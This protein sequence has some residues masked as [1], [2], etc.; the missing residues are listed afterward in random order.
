MTG[1][2][3]VKLVLVLVCCAFSP[4]TPAPAQPPLNVEWT[5]IG[6]LLSLYWEPVVAMD[7]ESE[8]TG[9]QVDFFS[10]PTLNKEEAN[11]ETVKSAYP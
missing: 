4:P 9:Y 2:S 3:S 1:E 7:L 5:L 10:G 8:V 11:R 6:P